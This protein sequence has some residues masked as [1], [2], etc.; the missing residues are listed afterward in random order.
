M[1]IRSGNT[2]WVTGLFL[3][4]IML[5]SCTQRRLSRKELTSYID[6][7]KRLCQSQEMAG[8]TVQIKYVPCELLVLQ[9]LNNVTKPSPEKVK[10]LESKYS[11]QYYFRVNFSHDNKEVIRQ[12]GSFQEYSDMLQT[13]SFE[14][15]KYINASD[16]RDDTL[17]LADYAFEQSFGMS[18]GNEILVAFK[19]EGFNNSEII[20]VNIGEFGLNIGDM[21]FGFRK[22]DIRRLPGLTEYQDIALN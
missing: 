22:K 1:R 18:K 14:M 4:A 11:G 16:D 7:N 15:G 21:R 20:N 10:Q 17:S 9:E 13:F 3:S 12:L 2:F 6:H 5:V 8:V 19:K